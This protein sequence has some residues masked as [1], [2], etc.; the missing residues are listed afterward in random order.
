MKYFKCNE[1]KNPYGDCILQFHDPNPSE[2]E[3]CY[4]NWQEITKE[5][6]LKECE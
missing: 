1:C 4:T 5:E 6:F 2:L 3:G